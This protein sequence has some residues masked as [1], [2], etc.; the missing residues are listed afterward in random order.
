MMLAAVGSVA[1]G[2]AA[3]VAVLL[4]SG[5]I[6]GGT[7]AAAVQPL[8]AGAA[9]GIGSLHPAALYADADPGVVDITARG[10]STVQSPFGPALERS[11]SSGAGVVL[12]RQGH[13]LTADHVVQGASSLSV[14]F[15]NGVTRR[16]R[17]AG[18]DPSTDLAVLKVDPSGLTLH[19]LPLGDSSSQPVGAPVAAIGDPFGYQRSLSVGIVSGLHRTIQGLNGSRVA[20][21]IQTD[22]AIDP[23]NS[24]GPLLNARGQ[25][26]GI[27]DQIATGNSGADSSTGVGFAV[28]SAAA[29][30]ELTGLERGAKIRHAYLGVSSSD[31]AGTPGAVVAAVAGG[32]PAADAGVKTGD[33]VIAVNRAAISRSD[34]LL[35][36]VAARAPGDKLELTLRRGSG[37]Q[38]RTITLGAR[39]RGRASS[40]SGSRGRG[41]EPS[42]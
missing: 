32:S 1:S 22:A 4:V 16:A 25:V 38:T 21:A 10:T 6:H 30:A 26:I 24:G 5:A 2:A 18:R 37:T 31:A 23:G 19:P 17:V 13:V 41:A 40:G 15:A 27:V 14:S 12:D 29:K 7:T 9:V 33:V 35:A 8:T 3:A 42:R 36:A 28:S 39:P 34:E 11:T 20:D